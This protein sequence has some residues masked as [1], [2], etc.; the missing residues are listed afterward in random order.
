ME[1]KTHWLQNPNKNY[2]GH[3]DFPN[4]KDMILTIVSAKWEE[5]KNP[6]INTTEAK[7]V[8]RFKEKV[9]PFICNQTNANS[10]LKSTGEKFMEDC[11]GKKIQLF[12]DTIVD[13]R[14]KDDI[15]CIRIRREKPK[16]KKLPELK[17][18]TEAWSNCV[19][20]MKGAYTID[21]IKKKY[22]I[23]KENEKELKSQ[24]DATI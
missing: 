4:G 19:T 17:Q 8:V 2:L 12:V 14:T 13:N 18:S 10:I 3:W 24:V 23:S 6:I 22:S 11:E 7:R 20:A 9:K 16:A 5:V 21:D 15:D 1:T